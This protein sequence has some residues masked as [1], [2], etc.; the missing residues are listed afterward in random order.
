[1]TNDYEG[2]KSKLCKLT[3]SL[4]RSLY[5][6][7][8]ERDGIRPSAWHSVERDALGGP[9]RILPF[10]MWKVKSGVSEEAHEGDLL[11]EEYWLYEGV[12][13]RGTAKWREVVTHILN[14]NRTLLTHAEEQV[15]YYRRK[16]MNL[17]A[18]LQRYPEKEVS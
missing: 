5:Y 18:V 7:N 10:I 2:E 15:E 4:D 16:I 11:V 9:V 17:E 6:V 14:S 3:M 1:M 13:I 8:G 12:P